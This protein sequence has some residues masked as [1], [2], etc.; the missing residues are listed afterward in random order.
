MTEEIRSNRV[1][2]VAVV[3]LN[4]P[5]RLNALTRTMMRALLAELATCALDEAVGCVVLAGAGR[6]FCAGGDVQV[7]ADTAARGADQTPER[8]ADDLRASM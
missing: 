1:G 7:Q 3:T 5:E 8:R 6:A 4:R 2:R